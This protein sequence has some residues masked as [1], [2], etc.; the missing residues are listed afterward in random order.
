MAGGERRGYRDR[1]AAGRVA[2]A[3]LIRVW[4]ERNG[5]SH[6]V[7]PALAEA[8][9]A[10][11]VHNSQL[12]MLRNGKLVSPG[13]EV[14]LALGSIN[15]WLAEHAPSGRLEAGSQAAAELDAAAVP[16]LVE[17]LRQSALPIGDATG[18]VL[19]PGALLEVFVGM[20]LPPPAF[21][22]RI[23]E[24]EAADL[25]AALALL[26]TAGR[27][28]RLCREHL[29]RA[30]PVS[31]PQRRERFAEVMAG[32]RDYGAA[33]LEAELQ[34]LRL[35]LASLSGSG[36]DALPPERFLKLLRQRAQELTALA[37]GNQLSPEPAAD[38]AEAIR[39][40]LLT[41]PQG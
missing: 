4:H 6:R 14:F 31:R 20:T 12:S 33:E 29:M 28:W 21:D 37:H 27:P 25:S 17:A 40:Q 36:E 11:R 13:P 5:W 1:L 7:L 41:L 38:L 10:G 18:T 9:D 15:L 23:E 39:A 3:H 32:Q 16:E 2:F 24:A 8:L 22:L 26:L 19:G 34:D 35:T 30:Y